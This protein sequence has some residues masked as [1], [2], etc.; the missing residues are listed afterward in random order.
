MQ[1]S[2]YFYF[3]LSN[4][5]MQWSVIFSAL[6]TRHRC[7][8]CW[9]WHA[10][11]RPST[12]FQWFVEYVSDLCVNAAGEDPIQLPL[13]ARSL[14]AVVENNISAL[15]PQTKPTSCLFTPQSLSHRA[16]HSYRAV[17]L[18]KHWCQT[19][20]A[21]NIKESRRKELAFFT[22]TQSWMIHMDVNVWTRL[23]ALSKSMPKWLPVKPE[24]SACCFKYE[25]S[26]LLFW[27]GIKM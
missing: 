11:K 23:W 8:G 24:L 26:F 7:F 13:C 10:R 27:C 16:E 6:Q 5:R 22:L 20:H 9:L 4:S 12:F 2:C 3:C 21:I 14:S 1:R 17:M 15:L 19:K 25:C 18:L